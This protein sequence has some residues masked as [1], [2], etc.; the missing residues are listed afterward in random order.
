MYIKN[1]LRRAKNDSKFSTN[2]LQDWGETSPSAVQSA[3]WGHAGAGQSADQWRSQASPFSRSLT[4]PATLT[5]HYTNTSL[6]MGKWQEEND[7]CL[8]ELGLTVMFRTN[9][10]ACVKPGEK[11]YFAW[12]TMQNTPNILYQ[13]SNK[14]KWKLNQ[15]KEQASLCQNGNCL[16]FCKVSS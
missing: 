1:S 2:H 5:A 13:Y 11:S 14:T 4:G 9:N 15:K 12:N 16:R 7:L 8:K 6:T 10:T 3:D